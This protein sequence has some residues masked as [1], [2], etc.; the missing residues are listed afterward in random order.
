LSTVRLSGNP[1]YRCDVDKIESV[2]RRCTKDT[3]TLSNLSY[4]ERL[5]VHVLQVESLELRR[6]KFDDDVS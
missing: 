3:G 1:R 2:Q 5:D 4:P 6:L